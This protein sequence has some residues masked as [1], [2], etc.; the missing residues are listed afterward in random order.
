MIDNI[1]Q[2]KIVEHLDLYKTGIELS[3]PFLNVR[4]ITEFKKHNINKSWRENIQ[5]YFWS[6]NKEI[7]V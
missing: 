3:N 7:F 6:G 4:E 5:S 1:I 2:K